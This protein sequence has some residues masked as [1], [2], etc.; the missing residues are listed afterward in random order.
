M[1]AT[2]LVSVTVLGQPAGELGPGHIR[3]VGPVGPVR[4]ARNGTGSSPRRTLILA[5]LNNLVLASV[6]HALTKGSRT[7]NTTG[8]SNTMQYVI[9][10]LA[11]Y[12]VVG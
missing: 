7:S 1:V 2:A 12:R 4:P 8:R 6:A 9:V 3:P 11:K 10:V 5:Q